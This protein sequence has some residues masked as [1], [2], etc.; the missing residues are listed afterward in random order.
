MADCCCGCVC[1]P[2]IAGLS[3]QI[4]GWTNIDCDCS[5]FNRTMYIPNEKNTPFRMTSTAARALLTDE[6]CFEGG[7][8]ALNYGEYDC[9]LFT[10]PAEIAWIAIC[11]SDGSVFL[12]VTATSIGAPTAESW[13]FT[14]E[15][16]RS[17][18][19]DLTMDK[20]VRCN[21]GRVFAEYCNCRSVRVR[22]TPVYR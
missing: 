4:T 5:D 8:S 20:T 9:G 10:N 7:W 12:S 19:T 21:D 22:V 11:L 13:S 14:A 18:C 15:E 16:L 3:I 1:C 6:V 17:G 2:N